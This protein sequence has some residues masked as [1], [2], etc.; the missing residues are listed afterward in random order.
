MKRLIIICEGQTEQEFCNDILQPHFNQF[1]IF[2][3]NP[4]IKKTAGGIV[5]WASLKHQIEMHLKQ[6]NT[7]F[8]TTLIDFYGIH[9]FHNY[10][11]W[12]QA[13]QHTDKNI[14]M[15]LMEQGMLI[16]ISTQYQ[17]KFIPYIQL[18]EFEGLLFCDIDVYNNG[19]EENE[20]LDYNYLVQTMTDNQNPELINDSS[21]TAP[22]KR[23]QKIIK[24][25]SKI[26]HGCLIAQDIGINKIR[27]KCPR[28][29]EWI[30]KLEKI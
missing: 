2:L 12:L 23:L 8:V 22:S 6:D 30:S 10:P 28:F 26:T 27:K 18:H 7:A 16:D 13:N 3:Q 21:I 1:G 20:F 24:N 15:D 17:Q 29:N 25:Y 11:N 5:S 4:T 9:A 19:F 14:G